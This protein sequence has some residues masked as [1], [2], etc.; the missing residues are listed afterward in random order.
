MKQ[1]FTP[2]PWF[3][4]KHASP[5]YLYQAGIYAEGFNDHAI[6]KSTPEDAVLI[7]AAPEMYTALED[8]YSFLRASGYDMH[9][10]ATALN[11]ARGEV[12]E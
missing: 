8:A 3:V 2:G 5:S 4:S 10:I 12:P 9:L 7:A 1:N 6:V 11:K